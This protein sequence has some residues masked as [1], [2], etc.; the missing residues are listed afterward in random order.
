M[1]ISTVFSAMDI[2]ASLKAKP[3]SAFEK[4]EVPKR[5]LI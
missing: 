1:E 5:N 2:L 3:T 4:S